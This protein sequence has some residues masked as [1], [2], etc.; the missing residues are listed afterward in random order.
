VEVEAASERFVRRLREPDF[1]ASIDRLFKLRNRHDTAK[2]EIFGDSLSADD[3]S[4]E[5]FR[6]K[7]RTILE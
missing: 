3:V 1:K 7:G 5:S 6:G 2:R 4:V